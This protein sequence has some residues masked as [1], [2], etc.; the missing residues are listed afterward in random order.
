[1]GTKRLNPQPDRYCGVGQEPAI[2]PRPCLAMLCRPR[3]EGIFGYEFLA[4][5][6]DT[7]DNC[8]QPAVAVRRLK[9]DC[10]DDENKFD[11]QL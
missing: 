7:R 8:T 11:L 4:E 10:H 6:P 1:M 9:V 2:Q 5:I 3:L